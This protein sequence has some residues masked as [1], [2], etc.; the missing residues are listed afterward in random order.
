MNTQ[1]DINC[2]TY[3]NR[4]ESEL[5]YFVCIGSF[6]FKKHAKLNDTPFPVYRS[7]MRWKQ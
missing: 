5:M 7:I 1:N 2:D 4:K 6:L 3:Q